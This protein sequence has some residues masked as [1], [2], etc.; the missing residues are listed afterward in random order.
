MIGTAGCELVVELFDFMNGSANDAFIL[1]AGMHS[2]LR[3]AYFPFFDRFFFS[4]QMFT[5]RLDE[6]V[7]RETSSGIASSCMYY[8]KQFSFTFSRRSSLTPATACT[9]RETNVN[10]QNMI[11]TAQKRVDLPYSSL[12]SSS[13]SSS[14]SSTFL[15]V[16]TSPRR[17]IL[18]FR[19]LRRSIEP[20]GF[21]GSA[22]TRPLVVRGPRCRRIRRV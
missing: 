21:R 9:K 20:W 3:E 22:L 7:S 18:A 10:R 5:L 19:L 12:K 1:M 16:A 15:P 13:R 6:C 8:D 4:R 17:K 11:F 14:Q 2:S